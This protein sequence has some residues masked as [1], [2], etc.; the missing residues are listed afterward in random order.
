MPRSSIKPCSLVEGQCGM[1]W[2]AA[3]PLVSEASLY[4]KHKL[5]MLPA[6]SRLRAAFS[7]VNV[8]QA[9]LGDVV[10]VNT[11]NRV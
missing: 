11:A 8:G 2:A 10:L 1:G 4:V 7:D 3:A 6:S 5:H 9:S